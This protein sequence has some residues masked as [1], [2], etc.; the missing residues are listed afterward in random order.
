MRSSPASASDCAFAASSDAFVVSVSSTLELGELRDQAL[1]VAADERLA[2]RDPQLA[3]A[4]R[5]ERARDAGDLLERQELAPVEEAVVA[6]VDLLRHAVGA[7]EVAAVG[8]RD[9]QVPQ[10]PAEMCRARPPG[11]P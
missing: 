8:D 7:A 10:R 2:A 3:R 4:E 6:A 5:D 1:E 9:A 11:K